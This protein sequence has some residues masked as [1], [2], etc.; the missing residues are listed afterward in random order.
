MRSEEL[1]HAVPA[2]TRYST[3]IHVIQPIALLTSTELQVVTQ[4][5]AEDTPAGEEYSLIARHPL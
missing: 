4:V 5:F 1:L 2:N 3:S